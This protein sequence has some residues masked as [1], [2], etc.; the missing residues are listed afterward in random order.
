MSASSSSLYRILCLVLTVALAIP[1]PVVCAAASENELS[2]EQLAELISRRN[3][4]GDQA[5]RDAYS[6]D[7]RELLEAMKR[8]RAFYEGKADGSWEGFISIAGEWKLKKEKDPKKVDYPF[9]KESPTVLGMY[10]WAQELAV[11]AQERI[12]DAS[13]SPRERFAILRGLLSDVILPLRASTA[14]S[15]S[16]APEFAD[17]QFF[18][19]LIPKLPA[20]M[21]EGDDGLARERALPMLEALGLRAPEGSAD[22]AACEAEGGEALALEMDPQFWLMKDAADAGKAPTKENYARALK[23]TTLAMMLAQIEHHQQLTGNSSPIPIPEACRSRLDGDLPA[24]VEIRPVDPS[25][26]E[27]RFDALIEANGMSH[28][29]PEYEEAFANDDI[30]DPKSKGFLGYSPFEKLHAAEIGL[31]TRKTPIPVREPALDDRDSYETVLELKAPALVQRLQ[32][33]IPVEASSS[34][35]YPRYPTS[36][37]AYIPAQ[38]SEADR[39]RHEEKVAAESEKLFALL[40]QEDD[41]RTLG[42]VPKA[43]IERLDQANAVDWREVVPSAVRKRLENEKVT[44]PFPPAHSPPAYRSWAVR[45]LGGFLE[46]TVPRIREIEAKRPQDRTEAERRLLMQALQA[47]TAGGEFTARPGPRCLQ[48]PRNRHQASEFLADALGRIREGKLTHRTSGDLDGPLAKDEIAVLERSLPDIWKT[49]SNEI[50]GART[51]EWQLLG[52][53][54]GTN[55]YAGVRLEALIQK[56]EAE[57]AKDRQK[58]ALLDASLKELGLDQPVTPFLANR[59]L[60]KNEKKRLWEKIRNDHDS[61]NLNL[62]NQRG[63]AEHPDSGTRY[64]EQLQRLAATRTLDRTGA[65]S[66]ASACHLDRRVGSQKPYSEELTEI[67]KSPDAQQGQHLKKI[68]DARGNP[69]EQDRLFDEYAREFE[70]DAD[71]AGGEA[72]RALLSLEGDLKRPLYKRLIQRAA[73][74]RRAELL[75]AMAELCA[76]SPDDHEKFKQLVLSTVKAQDQLNEQ[77][78]LQAMPENVRKEVDRMSDK[79]WK[80]LKLSGLAL[81][82]FIGASVLLTFSTGGAAAPA[83]AAG[84]AAI[85]GAMA[86]GSVVVGSVVIPKMWLDELPNAQERE[87]YVKTFEELRLTNRE[88]VERLEGE[89]GTIKNW[90]IAANVLFAAPMI[91]PIAQFGQSSSRGVALLAKASRAGAGS[92]E[93]MSLRQ[94]AAQAQ[95]DAEAITAEYLFGYRKLSRELLSPKALSS[96]VWSEASKP[97]QLSVKSADQVATD[98]ARLYA[99][100]FKNDPQLLRGYLEETKKRLAKAA[101]RETGSGPNFWRRRTLRMREATQGIDELLEALRHDSIETVLTRK[102]DSFS[103]LVQKIPYR[104]REVGAMLTIDG[105]PGM[106]TRLMKLREISTA[107]KALLKKLGSESAGAAPQARANG[108]LLNEFRENLLSRGAEGEARWVAIRTELQRNLGAQG[109]DAIEELLQG[110]RDLP[111]QSW[112]GGELRRAIDEMEERGRLYTNVAEFDEWLAI[113]RLQRLTRKA[114]P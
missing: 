14:V 28:L 72:R 49:F 113:K 11:R 47:C 60:S 9:P 83:I 88:S 66:A 92:A 108:A 80:E 6:A 89:I 111:A 2:I 69:A 22:I 56:H 100:Q 20:E 24:Q 107:R 84:A 104:G 109:P 82:L 81:G 64:Y 65:A 76:L 101:A 35:P 13:L 68:Y 103:E 59:V 17:R 10:D 7:T 40:Q 63:W 55:P 31:G 16:D 37:G 27:D 38:P 62:F 112:R 23:L 4:E 110:G 74:Q 44:L 102:G 36:R 95:Q 51:S 33:I 15:G 71:Q 77:L 78:G 34:I 79:D 45:E 12:N 32:K 29:S 86:V 94:A 99:A 106:G 54:I 97:V 70:L 1:A 90:G 87:R 19:K 93:R 105:I 18:E 57:T 85:S 30:G 48:D 75:T 21:F 3:A 53:Q 26:L 98:A 61:A 96:R 114:T 25:A 39:K 58:T 8:T 43:F 52:S 67:L 46:Q 42:P 41:V 50:S 5:E 73:N 91:K